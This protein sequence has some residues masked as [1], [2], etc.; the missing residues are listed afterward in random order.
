[1]TQKAIPG[2][3][4]LERHYPHAIARVF[5]AWSEPKAF[6]QWHAPGGDWVTGDHALDFRVGGRVMIFFGPKGAPRYR[7][8]GRVEDIVKP[9]L[10]RGRI[11]TSDTMFDEQDKA[12]FTS[13]LCTVEFVEDQG[14]TRLTLTDQSVFYGFETQDDR[15]GGWAEI[16]EKLDVYLKGNP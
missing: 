7:S 13:T 16:L 3:S 8:E 5:R 11:V 9:V 2:T 12:R 15:K 10:G 1:M 6:A 4:V 14:G